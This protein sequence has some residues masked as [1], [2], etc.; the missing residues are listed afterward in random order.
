MDF[1]GSRQVGR[2]SN[3][4]ERSS[5]GH[6]DVMRKGGTRGGEA[7]GAGPWEVIASCDFRSRGDN[8]MDKKPLGQRAW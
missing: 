8:R 1:P 3:P 5:S 7:G 2:M 6:G 4:I